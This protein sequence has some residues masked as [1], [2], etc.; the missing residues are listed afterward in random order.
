MA[1]YISRFLPNLAEKT[2]PLRELLRKNKE[3]VWGP[4]QNAAFANISNSISSAQCVAR[5][6]PAFATVL[7]FIWYR[8]S[9]DASATQ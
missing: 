9:S 6:D 8:G 1:T 2:G 5:C 4:V 7:F 3:W